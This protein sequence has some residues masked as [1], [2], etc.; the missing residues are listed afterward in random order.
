[1]GER[2]DAVRVLPVGHHGEHV[3]PRRQLGQGYAVL[4]RG[5]VPAGHQ[6]ATV[7]G[8]VLLLS[9]AP[10]RG[11][12]HVRIEVEEAVADGLLLRSSE[13]ADDRVLQTRDEE[14]DLSVPAQSLWDEV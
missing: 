10:Q 8:A 14:V 7:R 3:V 13:D 6:E 5:V 1:M 11:E 9:P 4:L 12:V 2:G